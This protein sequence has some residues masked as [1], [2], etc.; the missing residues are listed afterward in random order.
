MTHLHDGFRRYRD[1]VHPEYKGLFEQLAEGQRPATLMIA[2]SDSRIVP[3]LFTQAQPGELFVI[4]NAGNIVPRY[5]A[6]GGGEAAAIEYAVRVL[7]VSNIIVCGHSHCGAMHGLLHR[8]ALTDMPMVY[9]WL[10]HAEAARP[11]M[12]ADPDDPEV[13]NETIRSNVLA[14]LDNLQT[15]PCVQEAVERGDLTLHGWLYIFES[16]EL[17]EYIAKEEAFVPIE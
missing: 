12:T 16:G 2:C 9:R 14:Q 11:A 6:I 8:D 1:E 3:D 10:D 5:E 15:H 17:Y 4:R 7:K 13:M